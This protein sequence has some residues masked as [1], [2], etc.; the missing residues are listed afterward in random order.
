MPT[1]IKYFKLGIN[2]SFQS[3]T[4]L[5][6]NPQELYPEALVANLSKLAAAL[7]LRAENAEKQ[8]H[9]LPLPSIPPDSFAAARYS[10]SPHHQEQHVG[11][12][13]ELAFNKN[14]QRAGDGGK[15]SDINLREDDFS[16]QIIVACH[17]RRRYRLS[18]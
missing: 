1:I 15:S 9:A 13:N 4:L 5:Q 8:G 12:V 2:Y 14:K 3:H 7:R 16:Q 6:V 11:G 18:T 10:S 17:H